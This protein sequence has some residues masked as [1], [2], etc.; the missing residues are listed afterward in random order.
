M[1]GTVIRDD[2]ERAVVHQL[3]VAVLLSA[4][5]DEH[6]GWE[7]TFAFGNGQSAGQGIAFFFIGKAHFFN[8]IVEG[9]LWVLQTGLSLLFLLC[10]GQVERTSHVV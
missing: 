3:L 4:A 8:A 7:W 9:R 2:P 5:R 6:H 10:L 1:T